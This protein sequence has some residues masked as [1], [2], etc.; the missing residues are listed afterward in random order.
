MGKKARNRA[1]RRGKAQPRQRRSPQT[2]PESRAIV[3][4]AAD[5]L[6]ALEV[7]GRAVHAHRQD[8]EVLAL[9]EQLTACAEYVLSGAAHAD[10]EDLHLAWRIVDGDMPVL[11]A[12]PHSA[13][14]AHESHRR[15]RGPLTP[16]DLI[17][18]ADVDEDEDDPAHIGTYRQHLAVN[19][20]HFGAMDR[21]RRSRQELRCGRDT[22]AGTSCGAR[23]VYMPNGAGT[24]E[25]NYPCRAHLTDDEH[26]AMTTI[27]TTAQRDHDCPGCEATAGR[28]CFVGE[29]DARR[30]K[31]VDGEWARKYKYKDL[32]VHDARLHLAAEAR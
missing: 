29:Q 19:A 5:L 17:L 15:W 9:P 24:F 1:Q 7:Y 13:E 20:E 8:L 6:D 32:T 26:R 27:Y 30:L 4:A 22:K 12:L 23:L 3:S 14:R 16:S 2:P 31:L 21:A 11:G 25:S 18:C 10:V 28:L